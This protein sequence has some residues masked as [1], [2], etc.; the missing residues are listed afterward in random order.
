MSLP[1]L[2]G[3]LLQG[4]AIVLVARKIRHRRLAYNGLL[5]IG[6]SVLYHGIGESLQRMFPGAATYRQHVD[7]AVVDRWVL[8]AGAGI[9][10]FAVAYRYRVVPLT[11]EEL[12]AQPAPRTPL[13][14]NR[15]MLPA[16]LL[17]HASVSLGYRGARRE[18]LAVAGDRVP[19]G[20][21]RG[22]PGRV[23]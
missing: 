18:R 2:I 19:A 16:V 5:F 6:A 8:I 21:Q 4:M 10:L 22:G 1:L 9:F 3:L 11:D 13:V 23:L 17:A 14:N 15:W 7:A 12:E 20:A